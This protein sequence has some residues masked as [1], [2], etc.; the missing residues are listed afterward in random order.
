MLGFMNKCPNCNRD[1]SCMLEEAECDKAIIAWCTHCG[2]PLSLTVSLETLRRW[3]LRYEAEEESIRPPVP[4]EQI[5]MLLQI[6]EESVAW[7][8]WG[9]IELH[10]KHFKDYKYKDAIS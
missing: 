3:W 4:K 5:D 2:E 1:S 6:E 7:C 9:R 10:I 8:D